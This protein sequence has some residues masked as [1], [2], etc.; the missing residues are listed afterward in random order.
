MPTVWCGAEGYVSGLQH[1]AKASCICMYIH[2]RSVLMPC[3]M[4]D[5]AK[6][7]D[8]SE[9]K[10]YINSDEVFKIFGKGEVPKLSITY[11]QHSNNSGF[12]A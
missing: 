11:R 5:T 3:N 12:P 6:S 8:V 9:Q 1:A 10:Q 4:A 2:V 7:S